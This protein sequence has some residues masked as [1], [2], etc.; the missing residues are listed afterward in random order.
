MVEVASAS[1]MVAGLLAGLMVAGL[2][3]VEQVS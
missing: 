2:L 1:L 3:A